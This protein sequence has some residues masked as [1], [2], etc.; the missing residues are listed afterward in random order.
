MAGS[1]GGPIS[2]DLPYSRLVIGEGVAFTDAWNRTCS[3]T[4]CGLTLR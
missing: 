1:Y 3:C 4:A 2:L